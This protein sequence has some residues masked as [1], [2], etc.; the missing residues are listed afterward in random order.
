VA[1]RRWENTC[2]RTEI[3]GNQVKGLGVVLDFGIEAS[4]VEAIEDIILLH[5]AKILVPL[6]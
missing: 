4:E 6:G 1:G 5:F 2:I 3:I